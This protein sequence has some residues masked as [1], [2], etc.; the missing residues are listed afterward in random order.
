MMIIL[1]FTFVI[2]VLVVFGFVRA[3][4][5]IQWLPFIPAFLPHSFVVIPVSLNVSPPEMLKK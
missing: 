2:I 1:Q 5:T 4:N 3:K